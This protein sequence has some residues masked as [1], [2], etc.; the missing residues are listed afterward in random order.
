MDTTLRIPRRSSVFAAALT[1]FC[2]HHCDALAA[3]PAQAGASQSSSPSDAQRPDPKG[4]FLSSLKQAFRQDF[5]HEVVHGH[6]DVGSPPDVHRYYC[7]V[8]PK[9]G[10]SEANGVAGQPVQRPDGMTGIKG[11]AVSF[12]S[13]AD[14][15]QK[16]ILVTTGYVMSSTVSA[17]ITPPPPVQ[18]PPT[19]AAA[20]AP[21]PVP[22]PPPAPAVAPGAASA[23]AAAALPADGPAQTDV[24]VVFARFIAGQNAHDRAVVSEVLLDSKDF[25][26]A[27]DGGNSIWGYKEAMEAFEGEWK[28]TWRLDPQL[29]ELRIASVS[30][31]VAVLIAPLLFTEAGPGGNP[32]TLPIRWSGVFVKTNSGWRIASIFI[33]PFKSWRAPE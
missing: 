14:A 6:F 28:E 22:A 31:G 4:S 23:P 17:R 19:A 11:A 32:S 30:P 8:D 20:V 29:K 21:V 3:P 27:Q 10:K 33:T 24:M 1:L 26:W 25:V 12:Y 16:G 9:T 18:K 2:G 15:E 13:C 5:D 7:L